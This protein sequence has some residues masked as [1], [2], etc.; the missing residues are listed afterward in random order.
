[1]KYLKVIIGLIVVVAIGVAGKKFLFAKKEEIAK[2]EPPKKELVGIK[3]VSVTHGDIKQKVS[4]LANIEAIKSVTISTKLAGFIRDIKVSESS[5]VKVGDALVDIDSKE[6]FSSKQSLGSLKSSQVADLE[7][8]KKIYSR[9]KKLYKAGGLSLEKLEL[10]KVVV[11]KKLSALNS[12]ISKINQID[13]QL[14]YLHIKAPFSGYVDKIFL[15]KGDLAA[16]GKPILKLSTKGKKLT[17]TF[18]PNQVDLIKKGNIV[19]FNGKEIGSVSKIYT[20]ATNGLF[21][22]EV[23][24]KQE[25]NMP[26]GTTINI[27][28]ATNDFKGCIVPSRALIHLKDGVFVVVYDGKR[29]VKER[30]DLIYEDINSA[31]IKQCLT[32]KV[33]IGSEVKLT[34]LPSLGE[35]DIKG[36][37]NG[38]K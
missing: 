30:I 35:V 14:Q 33:A 4:F 18:A 16:A 23:E 24:L 5:F 9:N 22:A 2:L 36:Q 19:Y 26:I 31:I 25:L 15:H 38:K 3:T 1:M 34:F 17:F 11:D 28:I 27:D 37:S 12:T 6:L 13:N 21:V 7:V 32:K 20:V 8:A 29:F 10:S